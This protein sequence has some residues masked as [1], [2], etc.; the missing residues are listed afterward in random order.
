MI[1]KET[2]NKL[3]SEVLDDEYFVVSLKISKDN[4]IQIDIDGDNGVSIE[5]CVEVSRY[6]EHS[7]DRDEED[8]ELSVS[9][10]GLS[11]PY[12]VMRQYQKN[13]GRE[14]EVDPVNGKPF[15]GVLKEADENKF[16][17]EVVTREALE[18]KKKKVDV[19]RLHTFKYEEV[20]GVKTVISLK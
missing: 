8:F 17:V 15:K 3:I 4:K 7:L 1:Q 20:N 10:A 12:K 18:G 19:A 2:I 14:V 13:L 16:S 11:Q 6:V 5:K 9:S